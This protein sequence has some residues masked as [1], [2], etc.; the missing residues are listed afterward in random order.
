RDMHAALHQGRYDNSRLYLQEE[1]LLLERGTLGMQARV[2]RVAEHALN[3]MMP[4]HQ[5][6]V[7]I[8][9]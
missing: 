3:M 1:Q 9:E 8:H 7:M 5:S 2:Q 4:N 6:V